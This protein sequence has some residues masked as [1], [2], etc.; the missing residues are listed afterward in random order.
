MK[1]FKKGISVLTALVL[2]LLCLPE[3]LMRRITVFATELVN[4]NF[5]DFVF[6]PIIKAPKTE[7]IMLTVI[8]IGG[9]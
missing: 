5:K 6:L 9:A 2:V 1:M 8:P 7:C 3:R 4:E